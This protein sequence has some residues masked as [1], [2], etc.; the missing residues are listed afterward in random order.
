M[1]WSSYCPLF[2]ITGNRLVGRLLTGSGIG[3]QPA[4]VV[5]DCWRQPPMG[6]APGGK[7]HGSATTPGARALTSNGDASVAG[8]CSRGGNS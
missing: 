5:A 2:G 3:G 6:A 7:R 1:V 4:I 8:D